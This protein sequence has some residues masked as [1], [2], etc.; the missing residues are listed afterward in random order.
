MSFAVYC[1]L[2]IIVTQTQLFHA[3]LSSL[4]C[5]FWNNAGGGH[6]IMS[7]SLNRVFFFI[8]K[9]HRPLFCC[10]VL[11][12][13]PLSPLILKCFSNCRF[14]LFVPSQD[15]NDNP[16]TFSLPSYIVKISENIIAG[17]F[18]VCCVLSVGDTMAQRM[19]PSS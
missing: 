2:G 7:L 18:C 17:R 6:S 12:S 3:S 16:P 8:G 14:V 10:K 1:S 11:P 15:E 4:S 9:G 19:F 13:K 5:W